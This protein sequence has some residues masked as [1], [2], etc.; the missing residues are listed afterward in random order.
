MRLP[1]F[2]GVIDLSIAIVVA[3]LVLMPAREMF[4]TAAI[5]GD[6]AQQF[7][8]AL[9]EARTIARPD[10]G[11][12]AEDFARRLGEANM[13]DWAIEAAVRDSERA[14]DSPTRWRALLAA[15][16]AYVDKLDVVPGLDY[17]N[18]ALAACE[19]AR[20]RGDAAACP[21]W[22]QVR[23]KIYQAYLDAGVS[24]G[25][26]P[27]RDPIGFR[28]A[29]EQ[30]SGWLQV[31]LGGHDTERGSAAGSGGSAGSSGSAGSGAAP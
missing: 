29:G 5:K 9:A 18:R 23:M 19:T 3:V 4:A 24:S 12:A 27:H 30:R 1:R 15:S 25:I 7:A 20:D 22:E 21:S 11:R 28:K 6:D 13:K 10:D 8:I 2:V 16:V 26:N 31:R 17:A 14:K